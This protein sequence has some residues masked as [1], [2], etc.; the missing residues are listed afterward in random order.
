MNLLD[1]YNL[2][3]T[4]EITE[5]EAARVLNMSTK[6]LRSSMTRHGHK[7]P[8]V[9]SIMDKIRSNQ[10]TRTEAAAALGIDVRT[11]NRLQE[12]W[13]VV[14]PVSHERKIMTT[15]S[16]IKWDMRKK[17]AID[18]I[19]G[20]IDFETAAEGANCDTRTMRRWVEK[21][22]MKHL[23]MPYKDLL[24]LSDSRR[25]RVADGIEA[26]E[27]LEWSKQAMLKSIS[28]GKL[29]IRDVALNQVIEKRALA[30]NRRKTQSAPTR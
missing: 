1:V 30:R 5:D 14:R 22:L 20:G 3:T 19:S 8:L 16:Q 12:T 24:T 7:F 13:K 11:V 29:S 4:N 18:F 23:E 21:L 9:L 26:A 2:M 17:Y 25:R 15:M 10:V 6:S 27:N 28:D